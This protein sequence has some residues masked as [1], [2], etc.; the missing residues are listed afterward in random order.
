MSDGFVKFLVIMCAILQMKKKHGL[1]IIGKKWKCI[2]TAFIRNL[3]SIKYALVKFMASSKASL[4][5]IFVY[6]DIK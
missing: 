1:G 4:G 5:S 6:R 2:L 3:I